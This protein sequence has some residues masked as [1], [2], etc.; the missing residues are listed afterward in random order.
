ML[1]LLFSE[2]TRPFPRLTGH[3]MHNNH[4]IDQHVVVLTWEEVGFAEPILARV[5]GFA[6]ENSDFEIF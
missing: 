5:R 4:M 6:L 2:F 1:K 3:C